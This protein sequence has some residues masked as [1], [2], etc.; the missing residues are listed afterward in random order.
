MS[1]RRLCQLVFGSCLLVALVGC[2]SLANRASERLAGNLSG[3]ILNQDDP[4]TVREGLPSYLLLL[5]GMIEGA[6]DSPGLLL[7]A[8]RLYGAYAGSFVSDPVRSKRLATRA[9]GYARRG[10][11]ARKLSLCGSH[12]G[13]FERFEAALATTRADDIDAMHALGAAWATWVQAHRDDWDAIADLPRIEA[14]F[15]RVVAMDAGHANGEPYM[16]L[17][18]LHCLRPES[19]GGRPVLGSERFDTAR[20][21]AGGRNLM[22]S[23]LYAE[24]CARLLF[25]RDLHDA[26]LRE[27][28]DADP[29]AAGLTLSNTLAQQRAEILLRDGDDYF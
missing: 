4:E 21:M 29:R 6:P 26:L 27:V 22:A 8:A 15:E 1:C 12:E 17:G 16:Y 3:A 18:V 5:D 28:L 11:C 14:L 24:H 19:L 10:V 13:P 2:A 25:D 23:V 7:S 20:A 9:L